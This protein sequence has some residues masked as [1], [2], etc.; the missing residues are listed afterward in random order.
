M[1][2][3]GYRLVVLSEEDGS[4]SEIRLPG[5]LKAISLYLSIGASLVIALVFILLA[6]YVNQSAAMSRQTARISNLSRRVATEQ[7]LAGRYAKDAA[8]TGKL[9]RQ[10]KDL[11][12]AVKAAEN[13]LGLIDGYKVPAVDGF[14][15]VLNVLKHIRGILPAAVGQAATE[16]TQA[17]HTPDML[18]VQGPITSGF[19]WRTNPVTDS[20]TQFHD[21]VDIG[22]PIGTPVHAVANGTVAYAGWYAG[23][24]EYV[25]LDNGFGVQTFYGHNSRLLVQAGQTVKRGQVIALSGETGYATGPHVHFGLHVDGRPTNPLT[26]IANAQRALA[27]SS[28]GSKGE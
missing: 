28:S 15:G 8:L 4:T 21:G 12:S 6:A 27:V 3:P 17:A 9:N 19:G 11:V 26:F 16:A 25:L 5:T 10:T 1:H 13:K 18:P 24:G 22:V 23:Y 2:N 7:K 20:G 14:Q